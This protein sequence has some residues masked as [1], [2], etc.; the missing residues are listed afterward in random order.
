LRPP[1]RRPNDFFWPDPFDAAAFAAQ[2]EALFDGTT[3]RPYLQLFEFGGLDLS[4]ASRILLFN[5]DR[6][7]W[8]A[9]G[10]VANSSALGEDVIVFLQRGAAHHL[11]LRAPNAADPEDTVVARNMARA[12]I[13]KWSNL[14]LAERGLEGA[15]AT[16]GPR[17]QKEER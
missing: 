15:R 7:P 17:K 3:P 16:A 8:K 10:I 13:A 4:R 11:D 6:D 2:C 1:A 5:G 9:G 12:A 14:A